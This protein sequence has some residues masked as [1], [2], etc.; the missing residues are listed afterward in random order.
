L[1]QIEEWGEVE[2]RVHTLT[3]R[4]PFRLSYVAYIPG[5][6]TNVLRLS[7]CRSLDIHFNLG[8]NCL[9]QRVSSNPVCYLEYKDGHWLI[10]ADEKARPPLRALQAAATVLGY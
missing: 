1:L 5:F 4:Q 2:L 10:D 9:Y 7:R 6:F 8:K 3:G